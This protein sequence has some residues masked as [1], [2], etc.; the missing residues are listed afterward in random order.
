M[1]ESVLLLYAIDFLV[2]GSLPYVFFRQ[3]GR[4]NLKWWS[5][6]APFLLCPLLLLNS[7]FKLVTPLLKYGQLWNFHNDLLSVPFS[8][9]SIS[10]IFFTLGTHRIPLSLWHQNN[11]RPKHIVTYGAYGKIRHPFYTSFLL[12]LLG[13]FILYPHPGTIF[14]L[15]YGLV[16]LNITAAREEKRLSASE[17]GAEYK[18]YIKHTGRFFPK[19]ETK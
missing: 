15:I 14:T 1:N 7:Y 2:I 5:T 6:A 13:G 9:A 10:L 8:V 16:A 12:S 19:L 18:A 4:K 3:D 17:F 11:D